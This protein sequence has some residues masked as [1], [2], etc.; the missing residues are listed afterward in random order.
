M[1]PNGEPIRPSRTSI[2]ETLSKV[3]ANPPKIA[4]KSTAGTFSLIFFKVQS[5]WRSH[6]YI[7]FILL[8]AS[9]IVTVMIG[10][11]RMRR[12]KSFGNTGG[13]F[14]LDGKEGLLGGTNSNGK[15]D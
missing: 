2:L 3:V 9:L 7:G 14:Q 11:S 12:G 10:R 4:A 13:F 1:T 8:I 6:P 5:A 15:V